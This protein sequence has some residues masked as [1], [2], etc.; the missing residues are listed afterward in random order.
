MFLP[1]LGFDFSSLVAEVDG[2]EVRWSVAPP[3]P[4]TWRRHASSSR[5]GAAHD[6]RPRGPT[7][8]SSTRP[9]RRASRPTAIARYN[10][11]GFIGLQNFATILGRAQRSLIPVFTWNIT[12]AVLTIL[13]NTAFGSCWR[14]CS[15]TP[16]CASATSTARC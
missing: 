8:S 12:F 7:S 15:T 13:I 11:Y 5:R 3:F 9:C 16:T 10:D 2:L 1:E 4:P 6:R 14:S